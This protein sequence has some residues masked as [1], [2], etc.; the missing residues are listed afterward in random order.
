ASVFEAKF[1]LPFGV[2]A[3]LLGHDLTD[4]TSFEKLYA[5]GQIA[6]LIDKV[7][8]AEDLEITAAFPRL[9]GG[10]VSIAMKD[11]KVHAGKA[12][13]RK[14]EPSNPFTAVELREKFKRLAGATSHCGNVDAWLAWIDA[15]PHGVSVAYEELPS[16]VG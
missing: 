3:S 16:G 4:P 2:A 12:L 10:R 1:S 8:L 13:T 6:A 9:R 14:G 11:G 7:T 15:L 5:D